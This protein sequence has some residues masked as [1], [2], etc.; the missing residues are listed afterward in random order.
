MKFKDTD[1]ERFNAGEI[2]YEELVNITTAAYKSEIDEPEDEN[3][4]GNDND[5]DDKKETKTEV[6]IEDKVEQKKVDTEDPDYAAFLEFKKSSEYE[7]L[8]DKNKGLFKIDWSNVSV[9]GDE[10]LQDNISS[11]LFRMN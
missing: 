7:D 1:L 11:F 8:G 9:A 4:D 2:D 10:M 3:P 5:P 6:I